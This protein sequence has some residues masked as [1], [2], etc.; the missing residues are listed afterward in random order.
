MVPI[1]TDRPSQQLVPMICLTCTRTLG[2]RAYGPYIAHF[3]KNIGHFKNYK[4][5]SQ[6]M[7]S[8]NNTLIERIVSYPPTHPFLLLSIK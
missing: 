1:F 4:E 2:P 7:T 6:F 5:S 8:F 3:L